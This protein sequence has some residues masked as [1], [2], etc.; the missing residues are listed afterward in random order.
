MNSKL[1]LLSGHNTVH[2]N[3]A[4]ADVL[5]TNPVQVF[6]S[7]LRVDMV[8]GQPGYQLFVGDQ[9]DVD[10]GLPAGQCV[11]NHCLCGESLEF[12]DD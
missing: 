6:A 1:Q 7:Y 3:T 2:M 4:Q 9:A 8:P 10:T 11:H 5:R 12:G